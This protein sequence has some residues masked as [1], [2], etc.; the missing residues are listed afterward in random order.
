MLGPLEE[1]ARSVRESLRDL[2]AADQAIVLALAAGEMAERI[3]K[4]DEDMLPARAAGRVRAST[5]RALKGKT[6]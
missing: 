2:P 6:P 1:R 4:S 3:G 5:E